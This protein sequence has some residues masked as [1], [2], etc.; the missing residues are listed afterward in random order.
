MCLEGTR[1]S[2]VFRGL[3][4]SEW[5]IAQKYRSILNMLPFNSDSL[6]L[7]CHQSE[8]ISSCAFASVMRVRIQDPCCKHS[9]AALQMWQGTAELCPER[10]SLEGDAINALPLNP[11]AVLAQRSEQVHTWGMRNYVSN[12]EKAKMTAE[13]RH[14]EHPSSDFSHLREQACKLSSSESPELCF[15]T[16]TVFSQAERSQSVARTQTKCG[17]WSHGFQSP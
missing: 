8:R 5:S 7:T 12:T 1:V 14:L 10:S 11:L 6:W 16:C 13:H 9:T 4:L 2:V 3:I 15:T 17:T